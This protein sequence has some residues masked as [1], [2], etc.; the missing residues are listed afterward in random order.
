MGVVLSDGSMAERQARHLPPLRVAEKP[1]S[2]F[3]LVKGI[4]MVFEAGLE[5]VC[6]GKIAGVKR[7]QSR[8]KTRIPRRQVQRLSAV[9]HIQ[10]HCL[11]RKFDGGFQRLAGFAFCGRGQIATK[12]QS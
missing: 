5:N 4:S 6:G 10:S 7:F 8:Q 3:E 11:R 2:G 9:A 12:K 1:G